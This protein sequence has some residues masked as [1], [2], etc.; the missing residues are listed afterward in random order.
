MTP[1]AT[2]TVGT[3]NRID[4]IAF[5]GRREALSKRDFGVEEVL[6]RLDIIL[7]W[8]A[9]FTSAETTRNVRRGWFAADWMKW[10]SRKS[11]FWLELFCQVSTQRH[12]K[13][14]CIFVGGYIWQTILKMSHSNHICSVLVG[15]VEHSGLAQK[16]I[17]CTNISETGCRASSSNGIWSSKVLG[18]ICASD[19]YEQ[20][21]ILNLSGQ[22]KSHNQLNR[23]QKLWV[24]EHQTS[25]IGVCSPI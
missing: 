24:E 16:Q 23:V 20:H 11:Y 13:E 21:F 9:S 25:S 6:K 18:N 12:E 10:T 4:E 3:F 2:G 5:H 19:W 22:C 8:A 17:R 1:T 14:N 15:V 7:G